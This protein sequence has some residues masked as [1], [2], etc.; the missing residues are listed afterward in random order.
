M[1]ASRRKNAHSS[2]FIF[3]KYNSRSSSEDTQQSEGV[4]L[5]AASRDFLLGSAYAN[6]RQ[7]GRRVSNDGAAW[8]RGRPPRLPS[9]SHGDVAACLNA[10][11][12]FLV[13]VGGARLIRDWEE[14]TKILSEW[15]P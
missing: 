5:S 4:H 9:P 15:T 6:A 12:S 14:A 2:F 3:L 8:R 7:R 11:F 10:T 1:H 13:D